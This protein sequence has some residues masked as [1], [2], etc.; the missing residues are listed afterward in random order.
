M[1]RDSWHYIWALLTLYRKTKRQVSLLQVVLQEKK[2][3]K[4]NE[5]DYFPASGNGYGFRSGSLWF[6]RYH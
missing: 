4:H 5:E 6:R 1:L 3:K 2:G